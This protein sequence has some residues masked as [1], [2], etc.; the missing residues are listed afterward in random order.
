MHVV[1]KRN[2]TLIALVILLNI[3]DG[4]SLPGVGDRRVSESA[5]SLN[6]S[7]AN[8]ALSIRQNVTHG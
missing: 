6:E 3:P 7:L 8:A 1:L 4:L 2:L 5:R